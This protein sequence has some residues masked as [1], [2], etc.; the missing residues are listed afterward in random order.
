MYSKITI[1]R[2]KPTR[3]TTLTKIFFTQ[4]LLQNLAYEKYSE[5]SGRPNAKKLVIFIAYL[6]NF[7]AQTNSLTKTQAHFDSLRK[8]EQTPGRLERLKTML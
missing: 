2:K 7:S 5:A 4:D 6:S 8:L 3:E 1:F